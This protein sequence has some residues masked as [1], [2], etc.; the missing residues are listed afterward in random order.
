MCHVAQALAYIHA[1]GVIHRDVKSANVLCRTGGNGQICAKLADFGLAKQKEDSQRSTRFMGKV[2]SF[3]WMAPEVLDGE[4]YNKKADIF[5]F[6][7]LCYEILTGKTPYEG[8][9][10]GQIMMFVVCKH[11]RPDLPSDL[12]EDLTTLV[13]A[14]WDKDPVE[15]PTAGEVVKHLQTLID[16]LEKEKRH[17][18]GG[19]LRS[20]SENITGHSHRHSFNEEP[21]DSQATGFSS[22]SGSG[23]TSGTF[24]SSQE[25]VWPGSVGASTDNLSRLQSLFLNPFPVLTRCKA[26]LSDHTD[27]VSALAI[28]P[29]GTLYSAGDDKTVREWIGTR[30][31]R[32]L[33]GHTERVIVLAI[34]PDG[35]LYSGSADATIRVWRDGQSEAILEGHTDAVT[36]LAIAPDGT[37]Y[38]GSADATI[39]VWRDGQS[40]AILE[41][42]TDAVTSLAIAP[43]GTFFSGSY[44]GTVR[45]WRG[46]ECI[47]VLK[48]HRSWVLSL[49]VTPH[50][51]LFSAGRDGTVLM[52]RDAKCSFVLRGHTNWVTSLA[53]SRDGSTL[54]S[55]SRDTTVRCWKKGECVATLEGHTR[56]VAT[57]AVS[58]DGTFVYSGS[59]DGT[60]RQWDWS[61]AGDKGCVAE[62]RGHASEVW[63][64]ALASDGTLYSGSCDKTVR[65]WE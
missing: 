30:C 49:A 33:A 38:S 24:C 56:R 52:W 4:A 60:V 5:S 64:L 44:D 51:T 43:D 14:C 20:E 28:A 7:I 42:H 18:E 21:Q 47:K 12:P 27:N 3:L 55:G 17:M 34:A 8:K 62:L 10:E 6:A 15:R 16:R 32:V 54:F 23:G 50:G 46:E 19:D 59:N 41:G 2:G 58:P 35:T 63:A 25:L 65:R 45:Q 31:T 37:L 22:S 36:S 57:L 26:T 1:N 29:G 61:L 53:L 11:G 40:E 39:R 13:K 48:G 9:S